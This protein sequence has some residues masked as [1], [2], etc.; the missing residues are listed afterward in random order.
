MG[1]LKLILEHAIKFEEYSAQL[2]MSA[3]EKTKVESVKRILKQL[4]GQELVHKQKLET[5]D[6]TT[7]GAKVIAD[8]IEAIDVKDE[9][10]LTPLNEFGSLKEVFTFASKLEV[11]SRDM[12]QQLS[13]SVKEKK[14]KKLFSWL[15]NEEEKHNTILRETIESLGLGG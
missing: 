12:Y 10:M 4:A 2:Y 15:A 3:V 8:K 5:L 6:Y 7:L 14:A 1:E 13:N 11:D 9:L